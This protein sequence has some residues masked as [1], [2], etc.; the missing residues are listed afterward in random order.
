MDEREQLYLPSNKWRLLFFD[1]LGAL[2]IKNTYAN[3]AIIKKLGYLFLRPFYPHFDYLRPLYKDNSKILDK[4][5]SRAVATDP[6]N[7]TA[8]LMRAFVS[9]TKGDFIQ[10]RDDFLFV[11]ELDPENAIAY[12][13]IANYYRATNQLDKAKRAYI[14][15]IELNTDHGLVAESY[16][17]FGVT[18]IKT[19]NLKAAINNIRQAVF[20]GDNARADFYLG[21]ALHLNNETEA[22]QYFLKAK[23][24]FQ[25]ASNAERSEI[26]QLV[27]EYNLPFFNQ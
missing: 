12:F 15:V 24:E 27:R 2:Y 11:I 23:R 16:M 7:P 13:N 26:A 14:K 25:S 18:L 21:L 8:Y 4:E 20:L 17:Y 19:N 9:L 5:V 6:S 1:N 22:E 3:Q 10:A